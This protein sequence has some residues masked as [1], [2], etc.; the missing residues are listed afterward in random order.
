[1]K[2]SIAMATYNGGPYLAAQLASLAHQ[3]RLPDELVISDDGSCDETE[4]VVKEFAATAPFPVIW[5]RNTGRRGYRRNVDFAL[6]ATIGDIILLADQDDV[7][8]DEHVRWL[9]TPFEINPRLMVTAGDSQVISATGEVSDPTIRP[10]LTPAKLHATNR[11]RGAAQ[12]RA[13]LA[14]RGVIGHSMAFRRAVIELASPLPS[15][16]MPDEWIFLVGAAMGP[17]LYV[18]ETISRFRRYARALPAEYPRA[19]STSAVTVDP[20]GSVSETTQWQNL[21]SRLKYAGPMLPH[22][23]HVIHDVTAKIRVLTFEASLRNQSA[24]VRAVRRLPWI[25][26]GRYPR[27]LP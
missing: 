5:L 7:W 14:A 26:T 13:V 24:P 20:A 11:A 18:D 1:V 15:G 16:W 21:L 12:F 19:Q 9:V 23:D 17:I 6:A 22:A 25:L 27:N 3:D 4:Q 2:V 10:G 8:L